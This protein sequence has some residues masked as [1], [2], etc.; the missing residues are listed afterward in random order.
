MCSTSI[1]PNSKQTDNNN[2]VPHDCVATI[3]HWVPQLYR[4]LIVGNCRRVNGYHSVSERG[5]KYTE[6]RETVS[7]GAGTRAVLVGKEEDIL[8]KSVVWLP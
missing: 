8:D 6:R 4:R 1:K 3:S 7:G 2:P 5:D